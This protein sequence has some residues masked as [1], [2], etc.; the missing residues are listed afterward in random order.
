MKRQGRCD[1][2]EGGQSTTVREGG[3]SEDGA[4][5]LEHDVS[6]RLPRP[7]VTC[8]ELG[9]DLREREKRQLVLDVSHRWTKR[10]TFSPRTVL[11]M[12]A[13]ICV[14]KYGRESVNVASAYSPR[15]A[16]EESATHPDRCKK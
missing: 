16:G 10:R 5:H 15:R 13:M 12:A 14:R 6:Q 8:D 4:A 2:G 11:V 9:Y 3:K 7:D 1:G